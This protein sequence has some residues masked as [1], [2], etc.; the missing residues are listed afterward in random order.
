MQQVM[1]KLLPHQQHPRDSGR[2]LKLLGRPSPGSAVSPGAHTAEALR[3]PS[4]ESGAQG[5]GVPPEAGHRVPP[6]SSQPLAGHWL[7]VNN[8][9]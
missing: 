6:W 4:A 2:G 1:E 3:Q 7:L 5:L 9:K 8:A